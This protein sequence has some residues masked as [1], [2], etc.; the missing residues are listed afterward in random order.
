MRAAVAI[1]A[2]ILFARFSYVAAVEGDIV[3][4]RPGGAAID[5]P[6]ATFPHWIHRTQFKCYVCH[7]GIFE[8]RAGS[9]PVTMDA[10]GQGKYCGACHDGKTAFAVAFE[11]CTRCHRQ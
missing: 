9:A 8:M 1:A 11:T 4:T 7:D 5:T 2:L 10:I 6:S 3:F